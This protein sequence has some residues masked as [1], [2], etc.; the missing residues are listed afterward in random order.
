VLGGALA[1]M[2]FLKRYV[3]R[4]KDEWVTLHKLLDE[5]ETEQELTAKRVR[6]T[7]EW[8]AQVKLR[9]AEIDTFLKAAESE[10]DL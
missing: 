5:L 6:G 8:I 9:L 3:A 10:A 2:C 4:L 7:D 1:L